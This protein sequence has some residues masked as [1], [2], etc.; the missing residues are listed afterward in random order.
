[1]CYRKS[2]C[3]DFCHRKYA[4]LHF[5]LREVSARSDS[6]EVIL[7]LLTNFSQEKVIPDGLNKKK[8]V[9]GGSKSKDKDKSKRKEK[10][11]KVD[12]TAVVCGDRRIVD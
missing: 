5:I 8:S 6:S 4:Q 10:G 1:L 3:H 12:F 2:F 11:D 9:L 7:F